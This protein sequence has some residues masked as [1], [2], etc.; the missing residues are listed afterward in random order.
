[1]PGDPYPDVPASQPFER[2]RR[3]LIDL[4]KSALKGFN[5]VAIVIFTGLLV[6]LA[7]LTIIYNVFLKSFF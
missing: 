5:I 3:L 7:L 4:A 2:L 6:L 1:M